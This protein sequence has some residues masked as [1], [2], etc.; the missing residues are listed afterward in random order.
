[1]DT[2]Q[3]GYVKKILILLPALAKTSFV[4]YADYQINCEENFPQLV[5]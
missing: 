3:R 4:I 2:D 5:I 1:M